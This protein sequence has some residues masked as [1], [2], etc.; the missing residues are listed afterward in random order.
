MEQSRS[1]SDALFARLMAA[2]FALVGLLEATSAARAGQFSFKLYDHGAGLS[3]IDGACLARGGGGILFVCGQ[4]GLYAY[5]G[6]TFTS[7]GADQGLPDGG[8]IFD[9]VASDSG[10][11]GVVFPDELLFSAPSRDPSLSPTTLAFRRFDPHGRHFATDATHQLVPWR[12]GFAILLDR[13]VF[14]LSFG[15]DHPG[16]R[17]G[18]LS[19]SAA[20][21]AALRHVARLFA[22]HGQLW[23]S[24]DAGALCDAEPGSVRC[25]GPEQE[26]PPGPWLSLVHGDGSTVMARSAA[27]VATIDLITGH[28]AVASLPDQGGLYGNYQTY[29]QL[30]RTPDG[31][32]ATQGATGLVVLGPH[33]WH[34]L[35]TADGIPAGIIIATATDRTG[36]LWLQV[37]GHGLYRSLG[38][39]RW[40]A[41]PASAGL[42]SGLIWQAQQAPDGTL[43]VATD[44]GLVSVRRQGH[45]LSVGDTM[46]GASLALAIGRGGRIW[47]T[48]ANKGLEILDAHGAVDELI[49]LP[50]VDVIL[51]PGDGIAWVATENGLYRGIDQPGVG[52]GLERVTPPGSAAG[53]LSDGRGGVFYVLSGQLRH[54]HAGGMDV[55]IAGALPT[56]DFGVAAMARGPDGAIWIAGEGG[57]VR[58]DL[59]GD[60]LVGRRRIDAPP[61][62][63]GTVMAVLVDHHG[64]VWAGTG[65]GLLVGNGSRWVRVTTNDGM[66][67]DDVDQNGLYED[68]DGAIW[69]STS[70][71]L[72]RLR[73][74]DGWIFG[75]QATS[76]PIVRMT[77]NGHALVNGTAVPFTTA[78]LDLQ[79]GTSDYAAE[80]AIAFRYRLSGEDTVLNTTAS[81]AVHYPSISPGP[82]VLTVTAVDTARQ[83][84]SAPT[85]IRFRVATPL[86]RRWWAE[87][88]YVL[89]LAALV[90]AIHRLRLRALLRQQRALQA[91]VDERTRALELLAITDGMTGLFN[92]QEC[93]RRLSSGLDRPG[94]DGAWFVALIDID[95]FKSVNDRHG[96]LFG[97][98]VIK[99]VARELAARATDRDLAG[100]FG[101][102]EFILALHDDDGAALERIRTFHEAV[103]ELRFSRTN[104]TLR[105]TCSIGVT[106]ANAGEGWETIVGRADGALYQAKAAGRNRILQRVT[107]AVTDLP[108]AD[109]PDRADRGAS[110]ARPSRFARP[111]R[112][113]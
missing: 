10:R 74:P 42:S 95:H 6:R 1:L 80:N 57:L 41:L 4:E 84:A 24:T 92:R 21:H 69:I 71:G 63:I 43:W 14:T 111:P 52:A 5:D 22:V 99:S 76:P 36:Q 60:R 37:F 53:V 9:V 12:D 107:N 97:D 83:T 35:S 82:H 7:L 31:A 17:I 28:V 77:L 87:A 29:L 79:F 48:H 110:V 101:G 105:I 65:N 90:F 112:R 47:S 38:F 81:G 3:D 33:G 25:F 30:F 15:S 16:G 109:P 93:E 88:A 20:E 50:P 85:V 102:E 108:V 8:L 26:L 61:D 96:H 44:T 68:A 23:A 56:Q 94:Q 106:K 54:R 104:A 64:H 98:E 78:P 40:D 27:A 91:L 66:P 46:P 34:V 62:P 75:T 45:D 70:D 58:L 86:W 19:Y 73:D 2:I 113:A 72:I 11:I 59:A 18:I 67:W 100:R 13:Q 51:L 32:L 55:A 103:G 39:G 89:V 49:G